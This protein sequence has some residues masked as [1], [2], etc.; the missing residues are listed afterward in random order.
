MMRSSSDSS[1]TN[2]DDDDDDDNDDDDDDDN[3]INAV[4][5]GGQWVRSVPEATQLGFASASFFVF[6]PTKLEQSLQRWPVEV[7]K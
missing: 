7:L 3:G 1:N 6:S 2:S 4:K 5:M